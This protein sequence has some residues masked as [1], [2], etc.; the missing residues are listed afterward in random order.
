MLEVAS[1]S[2]TTAGSSHVLFDSC[3]RTRQPVIFFVSISSFENSF[4]SLLNSSLVCSS[5]LFLPPT[6]VSYSKRRRDT[7]RT[8]VKLSREVSNC[9]E[10]FPFCIVLQHHTNYIPKESRYLIPYYSSSQFNSYILSSIVLL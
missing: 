2:S 5:S 7:K 10:K 9:H 1:G 3:V 8:R 4:N 6:L